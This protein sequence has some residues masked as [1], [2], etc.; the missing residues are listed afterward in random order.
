MVFR[1]DHGGFKRQDTTLIPGYDKRGNLVRLF[2]FW[3]TCLRF[4]S[5]RR[6]AVAASH[7]ALA[8]LVFKS[9]PNPRKVAVDHACL[10]PPIFQPL[11][12]KSEVWAV[13]LFYF[14]RV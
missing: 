6:M 10:K 8:T 1:L 7:S 9:G 2:S 11:F 14:H 4:L 5:G 12:N 13:S 3:T